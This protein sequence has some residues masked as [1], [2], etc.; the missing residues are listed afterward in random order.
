[1]EF[2]VNLDFWFTVLRCT[3]PVLLATMAALIASRSGLLNL[4]LEGTMTIAALCGVLG[5]GFTGSLFAGRYGL[6]NAAGL[7]YS[8]F[9]SESGNHWS[10]FESG[11]YRWFCVLPVLS[12][13]G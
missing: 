7:F 8:A 9:K 12:D 5:S 3:T 11:R 10:C 2:L 6:H 4:G 1:M 13:W